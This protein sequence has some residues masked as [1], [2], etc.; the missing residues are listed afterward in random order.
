[1]TDSPDAIAALDAAQ[2]RRFARRA[3]LGLLLA[4]PADLALLALAQRGWP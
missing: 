4:I 1:M 2:A 3:L